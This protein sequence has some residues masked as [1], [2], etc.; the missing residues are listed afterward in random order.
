MPDYIKE[1]ARNFSRY[2]KYGIGGELREL[3]RQIIRLVTRV[4]ST[5]H[6]APV[7][8]ELVEACEQFKVMLV[9][10]RDVN[11]LTTPRRGSMSV[12]NG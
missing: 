12:S 1:T 3:S 4:N 11:A 2:H 9:S 5:K 7:F 6:K 10:V 8:Q